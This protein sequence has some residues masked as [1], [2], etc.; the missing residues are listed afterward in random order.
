MMHNMTHLHPTQNLFVVFNHT[1]TEP[2][3]RDAEENFGIKHIIY[4]SE[5]LSHIWADIPPE[6]SALK[7]HLTPLCDWIDKEAAMGDMILVQG[8]F[9]ATFL[10]V[11]F[12]FEQ[13]LVHVYSTTCR[14]AVEEQLPDGSVRL[15]RRFRHVRFR[16]YGE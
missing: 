12:C 13:G 16:N 7:K 6:I 2:Q 3:V 9:G 14:E 4:P 1:L 10:L 8:D 5:E 11:N 15:S